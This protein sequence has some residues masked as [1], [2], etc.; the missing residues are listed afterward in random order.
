ML[1]ALDLFAGCGGLSLGLSRAGFDVL[2]VEMDP[3]AVLAHQ[4]SAGPCVRLDV[5]RFVAPRSVELVAGGPPCQE[6]SEQG[7]KRG[8]A[9]ESGRLYEHLLRIAVD[10]QARALLLENVEGMTHA[11]GGAD[12]ALLS[13]LTDAAR[14]GFTVSSRVL[15]AADFGVPQL[16]KRL[17][18]VGFRDPADAAAF[19]WPTPTHGPGRSRPW[20]TV[21]EA[22]GLRGEFL[23]GGKHL[24][25]SW[26]QGARRIDVDGPGYTVGTRDNADWICPANGEAWRPREREL[27]TLQGFPPGFEFAGPSGSVHKQIGNAVPPPLGEALGRALAAVLARHEDKAP[28]ARRPSAPSLPAVPVV[29]S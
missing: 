10:G 22:L 25:V 20:V 26:W 2:G 18:V 14:A 21:R 9:T 19:R 23:K 28:E 16:R 13:V 12:A 8:L 7:R 17:F 29:Q 5:R 15:N 1:R 27:A 3:D 24:P 6:H 11:R 4:R